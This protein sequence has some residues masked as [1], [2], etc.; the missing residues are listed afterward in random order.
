MA[1][2]ELNALSSAFDGVNASVH[3][4]GSDNDVYGEGVGKGKK[5][6]GTSNL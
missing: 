4:T 6:D 1:A 3:E 2:M 5:A